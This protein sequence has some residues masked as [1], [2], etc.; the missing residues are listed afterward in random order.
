MTLDT[1]RLSP[2]LPL[3]NQASHNCISVYHVNRNESR[4]SLTVLRSCVEKVRL[5]LVNVGHV[6]IPTYV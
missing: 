5:I 3:P 2:E 4:R 6:R 1:V